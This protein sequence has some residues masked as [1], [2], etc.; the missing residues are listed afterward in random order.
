M[1][2]SAHPL[3]AAA[4]V[5]VL[6]AGGNA[7]D[8]A[9]AT[10]FVN[11]VV[12]PFMCGIG[13][14]GVMVVYLAAGDAGVVNFCPRAPHTARPDM[15]EIDTSRPAGWGSY[16]PVKDNATRIGYRAS[17][18]PGTVAGLSLALEKYGTMSLEDVMK[19][20][21]RLA[22]DGY[23][24]DRYVS[25]YIGN[26]F[27]DMSQFPEIRRIFLKD[28][29][30]PPIGWRLVQRDLAATLRKVAHGGPEAFYKGEIGQAIAAHMRENGGL[31]D[32]EDLSGYAPR[33]M[34]RRP[35]T[36][37]GFDIIHV[38]GHGGTIM[39][40][41]LNILEGYDIR[42]LEH[43]SPRYIH[44]VAE[45][46][47]AA[48][49]DIST[50]ACG[51]A[52]RMPLATLE[53]K[54]HAEK[55]RERIDLG[56]ASPETRPSE[57]HLRYRASG[58][59]DTTHFSA[60]DRDRN[61]VSCT[62]TLGSAFGSKVVVPGTGI[63]LDSK[64]SA[65]NPVPGTSNSI[66][67]GIQRYS[68]MDPFIVLKDGKP[69]MALGSP[70]CPVCPL[71]QVFLNV[72]EFGMGIQEAI[73]APRM[74]R[75]ASDQDYTVEIVLDQRIPEPVGRALE[76]MGHEVVFTDID[77]R[78]VQFARPSAILVDPTT[79]VLHGGHHTIARPYGRAVGC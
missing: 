73:E 2:C 43:N 45:A 56:R 53:S 48:F 61:M 10:A 63:V 69:F 16:A 5:Q 11:G 9:V 17:L 60:V 65:F 71:T 30:P 38:P 66:E 46:V 27:K 24:I 31:I 21:I 77:S 14:G 47:K 15:F 26:E 68:S 51:D 6:K 32:E 41:I 50:V 35:A 19:P 70:S 76:A 72:T 39:V 74:G 78:A 57:P 3:S 33:L 18:V 37:H 49:T 59:Y 28:G 20:A 79:G 64:M 75:E 54:G 12:E 1:V 4:G 40:E 13:G 62:F 58:D 8:A 55:T 23:A 52:S 22:E 44:L 67:P 7:V 42:R 36:Y 34:E 29:Y 25:T